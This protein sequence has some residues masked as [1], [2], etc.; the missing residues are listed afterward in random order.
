MRKMKSAIFHLRPL[1][2][3]HND[4]KPMNIMVDERDEPFIIDYGSCQPFGKALI[5]AGTPGWIDEHFTISAQEH[6]QIALKK[7]Q[8]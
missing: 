3:A 8:L 6:D 5:I 4:L 7:I 2:G 1:G